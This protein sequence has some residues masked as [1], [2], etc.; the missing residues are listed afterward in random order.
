M[1]RALYWLGG[2]LSLLCAW[3][4]V[5]S[6][7]RHWDAVASIPWGRRPVLV[8][9]AL[10][11]V[12][13]VSTY[14]VAAGVWQ[15]CLA[16]LGTQFDYRRAAIVLAI[17]QFGKYLPGNVGHHVGRLALARGAGIPL[18]A[19]VASILLETM[20]EVQAGVA[21]SLPAVELLLRVAR[22]R[23]PSHGAQADA[24]LSLAACAGLVLAGGLGWFW[25]RGLETRPLRLATSGR[26]LVVAWA[27]LCGSFALGG[28]ALY[29][30][31]T[32]LSTTTGSW[33][34]VAG[35][36]AAAWL[37]GFLVPGSPA[38]LGIRELVLLLGL[39][40]MYGTSSATMAAALLRLVTVAGDGLVFLSATTVRSWT[41]PR[42]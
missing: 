8:A 12:L 40:P 16:A 19:A 22:D 31:C 3:Y 42:A 6:L 35:V 37:L 7:G 2:L 26:S 10:A 17:S 28:T 24:L 4:F 9:S 30:L 36:Y 39:S 38:G 33:M 20:L 5:R 11:L 1:K 32:A 13:Y 15:R 27:G 41:S 14:A 29:V 18:D 21:C 23:L 34:D 25:F